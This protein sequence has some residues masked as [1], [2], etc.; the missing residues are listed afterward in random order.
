MGRPGAARASHDSHADSHGNHAR[1]HGRGED[2]RRSDQEPARGAQKCRHGRHLDG[3]LTLVSWVRIPAGSPEY[4]RMLPSMLAFILQIGLIDR[5]D[6]HIDSHVKRTWWDDM[7][8][9]VHGG[10][11]GSLLA[12]CLALPCVPMQCTSA[13]PLLRRGTSLGR[14]PRAGGISESLR[15]SRVNRWTSEQQLGCSSSNRS[16]ISVGPVRLVGLVGQYRGW[17]YLTP[18]ARPTRPP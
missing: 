9:T 16:A 5:A 18:S 4:L 12:L 17:Y 14:E 11:V 3:L 10:C 7:N 2:G 1:S 15:R 8:V 13:Y 6:S